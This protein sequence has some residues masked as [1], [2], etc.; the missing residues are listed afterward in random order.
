MNARKKRKIEIVITIRKEV[1]LKKVV[2][3]KTLL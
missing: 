3:K 2:R 1:I